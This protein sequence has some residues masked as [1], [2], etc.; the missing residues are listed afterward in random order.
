VADAVEREVGAGRFPI[1]LGGDCTITLGVVV[2]LQRVRA[3][4][5]LAYVD[6]DADLNSPER[7]RSGILDATGV[8]H[9]LGIATTPLAGI[10]RS[11]PMLADHALVLLGYD[12]TDP[13]SF[14]ADALSARPALKH[15]PGS[16]APSR[17]RRRHPTRVRRTHHHDHHSRG[18]LRHRRRRLSRPAAGELPHYGM[19][20]GL[21]TAEQVLRVLLGDPAASALVLTEVNPT[22]DPSGIQLRRYISTVT[23]A[24]AT[25]LTSR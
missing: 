23:A 20:A 2:R 24:I 15:Y 9:L 3:D 1:V 11:V 16:R 19:G 10:G 12:P 21:T 6:G 4:L 25:G 17:P 13:D 22:H 5:R 18:P 8:A 7:I 14:D